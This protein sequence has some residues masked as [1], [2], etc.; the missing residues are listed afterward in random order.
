MLREENVSRTQ[1][2]QQPNRSLRL[3]DLRCEVA[4]EFGF[5]VLENTMDYAE[6]I[7]LRHGFAYGLRRFDF[8]EALQ[9]SARSF[10]IGVALGYGALRCCNHFF[11]RTTELFRYRP[12]TVKILARHAFGTGAT[13]EF[14]APILPHLC[15]APHQERS[16]L[17][18]AFDMCSA[19][20][21]KVGALDLDGTQYSRAVDFFAHAEFRQVFSGA[22]ANG[23]RPVLKDNFVGS[24]FRAFEDFVQGLGTTQVDGAE[25]C[26]EMKRD[27]WPA[28]AFLKHG[29]EQVLSRMLLHMIEAARPMDAAED[30]RTTGALVH[31]VNDFVAIVAD[32]EYIRVSDFSQI[33]GL[34]S[35]G[36][37]KSGAIQHQT[38]GLRRNSSFQ[39]RRE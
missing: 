25:V 16:N 36:W 6:A 34:A 11:W 13:N 29:R 32:V 5:D 37:I 22:I 39:V 17:A 2:S 4:Q 8:R 10:E 3:R 15:A 30:V 28:I 24:A 21:L 23:H 18:G 1:S 12:K 9:Q 35:G 38:Q 33:M 7:G 31:D 20:R 19:A 26:A 14:H 27:R